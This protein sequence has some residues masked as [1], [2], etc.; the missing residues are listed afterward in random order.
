MFKQ[1]LEKDE[2]VSQGMYAARTFREKGPASRKALREKH[3]WH[4]QEIAGRSEWFE[5]S[6]HVNA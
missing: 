6:E 1:R 5:W 4:V 3:T 2:E